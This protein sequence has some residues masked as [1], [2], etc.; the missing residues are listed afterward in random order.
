MKALRFLARLDTLPRTFIYVVLF[1]AAGLPFL[2]RIRLPL[3]VWTETRN[4]FIVTEATPKNKIVAICS[5]WVAGSQ[6]ENWPQ[7]EALVAHLMLARKPFI[8]F[9]VDA[10]PMAPQMAEN[11]N[12]RQ[13]KRYGCVYGRDWVNL[14][15]TRGAPLTFAA[16]G[17][18]V[19]N[20]FQTD[21]RQTPT[22]DYKKLPLMKRVHDVRDFG[23]FWVVDYQPD[24]N[25][26]VFLDPTSRVPIV[27]ACAG[28]GSSGYYPYLASGQLK[29]MMVGNRGA[30]EY[31]SLL[32][33]K[34]GARFDETDMRGQ[35]LLVPMAF[36]YLTII[37]FILAGNVGMVAR[38]RLQAIARNGGPQ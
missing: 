12:E 26:V 7:Y 28:V 3:Y 11:I 5:N 33:Q 9:A 34:Y 37:L 38:R 24:L 21:F 16:I 36:G 20:V 23:T 35:K 2:V 31:E 4:A 8:V 25:W 32:E 17:R 15:L 27:F 30:A 29:G 19:K 22:Q 13:A 18:N 1:I 6:G 14:G 10:D